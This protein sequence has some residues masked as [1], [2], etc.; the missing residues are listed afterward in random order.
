MQMIRRM[1]LDKKEADKFAELKN[2]RA[3]SYKWYVEYFSP[4]SGYS[5]TK[6][7]LY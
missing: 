1:F 2:K 7:K 4:I 5:V 6:R 3:R